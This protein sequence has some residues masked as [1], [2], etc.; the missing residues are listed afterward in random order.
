M[1]LWNF[2]FLKGPAFLIRFALAIFSHYQ[3][4]IDSYNFS[5]TIQDQILTMEPDEVPNFLKHELRELPD[6]DVSIILL[7]LC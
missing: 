6:S 1:K 2:F 4:I 3:S 5:D 7:T